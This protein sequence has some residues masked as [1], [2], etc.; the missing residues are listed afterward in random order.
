M[1]SN[2]GIGL[3]ILVLILSFLTIFFASLDLNTPS[4]SIKKNIYKLSLFQTT[5]TILTFF[6]LIIGF[7]NSDFSL[8]N[9]Y[10]NSHTTKPLF[11]KIAGSWGNHEGSLLLWV[12]ILVIFSY[13]FLVFNQTHG[14]KFRLF[15]L[16]FQNILIL[17]FLFFL[18]FNSNPFNSIY[19]VP[20]EGLGL[21]PILQDPA[22]AI[23]PPLLYV[24]FVGCSIYFSAAMASLL[25][26]YGGKLFAQSIKTWVKISWCF[27]TL[28][29]II[30]SIWAYYELG[31][32]GFWFWDPVENA[33]L[34]PWFA[35]TALMHSLI[36]LEKRNELYFWVI[37]LCLSTFTLSVTGTFLVRSGILN[38]VHTFASDP[39]RGI[40]ILLFLSLMIFSSLTIF[41]IKY[42]KETYNFNLKS[43]ETFILAN[44]WFMVFFLVTVLIGILYPIFLDVLTNKKIS[45]GP[46][47]FNIV[48]IPLVVPLMFLMA[49]GPDFRWIK[50]QNK[51]IFKILILILGALVINLL[52]LYFFGKY[53]LLSNLIFITAIFLVLHS[54]LDLK[55]FTNKKNKSGLSRVISHFGFGLLVF[56]IGINY[57]FSLEEDFNLKVGETK[58]INSYE[59]NFENIKIKDSK[60]YKAVIGNFKLI[61]IENNLVQYLYPEIRIYSNPETLTYEAAIKTKINSDLYLTMSNVSRSDY[62][63][64][65]FQNKPFMIWIWISALIIVLGGFM[66]L[67][68]KK[69]ED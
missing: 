26:G 64:I 3:I 8:I 49:V 41:F 47:F 24:G 60:N 52:I 48:I 68:L 63:N 62:Y 14:K 36:V 40:Y 58:K 4:Q 56:F 45:V 16:I 12:N 35:I 42:K 39:S 38:S 53:S 20:S 31:W 43:R 30:G 9:V 7:I 44:N 57:Q 67:T 54:F 27:Q 21:N 1:L 50:S 33:S 34:L 2:I 61:N 6:T 11:Y 46:P 18:L 37:I 25:S 65:K 19:P 5:F 69:N 59:I 29:I 13:L 66:Q 10:E 51:N 15:T 23:H 17:G 22:L 55:K 28:G 32:G